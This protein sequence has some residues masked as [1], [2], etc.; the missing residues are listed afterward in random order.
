MQPER[1]S[2]YHGGRVILVGAGPGDPELITVKGLKA[3]SEADVIVYDRLASPELLNHAKRGAELIY[4]G[5]EAG[6]HALT[7]DEINSILVERASR[8]LVVVRLKGGDPLVYGRGEEEC[9]HVRLH[10][11]PCMVIPGVPSFTGGS[12]EYLIPLGARGI[13]RVFTVVTG[14]LAGDESPSSDRLRKV[15]EASDT[16]VVLMG[17]RRLREI[18][19]LAAEVR[20]AGE[21]VVMVRNATH[22]DSRIIAGTIGELLEEGV[23]VEPPLLIYIGGGARW[24]LEHWNAPR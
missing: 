20:G 19:E 7:Q 12:S 13:S 5:K 4:A 11:I 22:P 16:V 23:E 21:A 24:A 18:L 8:G 2:P 15:F 3:L 6:R 1:S 17:A 9:L 10:G 14:T